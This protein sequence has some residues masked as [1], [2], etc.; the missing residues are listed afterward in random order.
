MSYLTGQVEL[1]V[2]TERGS[3]K[4][5]HESISSDEVPR[6]LKARVR[7]VPSTGR[8][9]VVMNYDEFQTMLKILP[10]SAEA[11]KTAVE[12]TIDD[13][14]ARLDGANRFFCQG[15]NAATEHILTMNKT[16]QMEAETMYARERRVA[17]RMERLISTLKME[18][19]FLELIPAEYRV[20]EK[21]LWTVLPEIYEI[22]NILRGDRDD[23]E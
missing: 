16:L 2:N 21:S 3:L 11:T 6:C 17:E 9:V 19:S 18:G 15:F 5:S 8:K 23:G 4:R 14:S 10:Q 13:I 20:F 22:R 12:T 1:K 7:E